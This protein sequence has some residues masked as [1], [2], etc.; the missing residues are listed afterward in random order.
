M[1]YVQLGNTVTLPVLT[2]VGSTLVP[3]NADA[4]P[5]YAIY[6]SDLSSIRAADR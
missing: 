3:A 4:D 6:D 1:T 5:T 2:K